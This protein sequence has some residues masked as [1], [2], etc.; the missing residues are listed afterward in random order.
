MATVNTDLHGSELYVLYHDWTSLVSGS[1]FGTMTE[2]AMVY[3]Q[4]IGMLE[5]ICFA[6][7]DPHLISKSLEI[8]FIC[9]GEAAVAGIMIAFKYMADA[10]IG[11]CHCQSK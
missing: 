5:T 10:D 8:A 1:V 4:S 7:Y 2:V 3:A 9:F 6:F 11:R